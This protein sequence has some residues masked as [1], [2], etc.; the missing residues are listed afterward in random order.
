MSAPFAQFSAAV[1][2]LAPRAAVVLGSGLA[3][4]AASFTETASVSFGDVPGLVPTTVHGHRGRLA[5]GHWGDTPTLLFHGR[6]H[7]YEGHPREVVTGPVRT[8]ATL[9]AKVLV[10]TNAAGG[11]RPE[12][13][14]GSL[15]AIRG[16][17]KFVGRDGWRTVA[18][19]LG[20]AK[21]YSPRLLAVLGELLAG[22]YAGVTGPCYETPTEIRALAG[23]GADAVGMSTVMEAEAGAELGLE[24][25]AVSCITNAA[26]GMSPG[27]LDHADVLANAN[28][29]VERLAGLIGAV[30]AAS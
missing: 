18:A 19:G 9:G 23:C 30:I 26:A 10:L 11:I 7:F 25:A 3:G 4:V 29:A 5:V 20:L 21:P 22:V 14:P 8:A 2:G 12:L 27:P 1:R 6:L 28:L 17:L 24:V 13:G 16:H 15:M